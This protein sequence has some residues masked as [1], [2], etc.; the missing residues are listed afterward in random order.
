MNGVIKRT[1]AIILAIILVLFILIDLRSNVSAEDNKVQLDMTFDFAPEPGRGHTWLGGSLPSNDL[2]KTL[3]ESWKNLT[4]KVTDSSGNLYEVP[5]EYHFGRGT[6]Y[7]KDG[8]KYKDGEKLTIEIDPS[9]L[10]AGYHISWNGDDSYHKVEYT[11]GYYKMKY[12]ITKENMNAKLFLIRLGSMKTKFYM[13]GGTSA[14]GASPVI[15]DVNK[16][17]S[18]DFPAEPTKENLHFG[19]WFTRSGDHQRYWTAEDSF[20]DL[21]RDWWQYNDVRIDPLYDG[22]FVL[23]ARWNAYVTFDSNGGT[24]VK[25]AIVEEGNRVSYPEMPT[26]DNAKFLYWQDENGE[27]YDW[28][29]PVTKDMKLKAIW[30]ENAKADITFDPN[31]GKWKD[32]NNSESKS[33]NA[34]VGKEIKMLEAPV[35]DGYKF[36]G[37]RG[38]MYEAG[39]TYKVEPERT[40][41]AV[42]KKND[43][44]PDN[45]DPSLNTGS[46]STDCTTPENSGNKPGTTVEPDKNTNNPTVSTNSG[47]RTETNNNIKGI[48]TS[49]SLN[50]YD[51]IY[52]ILALAGGIFIVIMVKRKES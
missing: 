6:N 4:I 7:L 30:Q 27:P 34:E 35:R 18:V 22:F 29:K 9:G 40:F 45:K 48:S 8:G 43:G 10:P 15:K 17:N 44:K 33:I 16:N 32:T 49:D 13:M 31:N 42:W 46:G 28:S 39:A 25:K 38:K 21:N 37:W 11:Q 3:V 5:K 23:R 36:Q 51:Y 14:S 50:I 1:V 41:I 26:K 2:E 52:S 47:N 20:S 12:T 19:G 24:D